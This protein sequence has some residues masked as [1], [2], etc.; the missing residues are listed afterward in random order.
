MQILFFELSTMTKDTIQQLSLKE[1]H[2]R[3]RDGS[4]KSR[5]LTESAIGS[6]QEDLGA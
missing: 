3:L 1:I 4:L 6:Y 5:E 2:Q